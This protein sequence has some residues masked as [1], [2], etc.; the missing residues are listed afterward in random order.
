MTL[1]ERKFR[2]LLL[3]LEKA[4]AISQTDKDYG[5]LVLKS[6]LIEIFYIL[7][8]EEPNI[9]KGE[10][11]TD[12]MGEVKCYI[13]TNYATINTITDIAEHFF[14]SREHLSRKF[15]QSF[16]ISIAHYLSKRRIT[17]SLA[18]L[19]IMNVADVAYAVGFHSQSAFIHAFKQNMQCL[20]SEY[21]FKYL[22]NKKERY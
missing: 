21:K 1:S 13:D 15:V 12:L 17:E 7:N 16:G 20:P 6:L 9:Q 14:Y 18:L 8:S 3:L 11:L 5:E 4:D 22:G 2:E 19:E 10:I